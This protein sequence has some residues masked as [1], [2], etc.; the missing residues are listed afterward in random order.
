MANRFSKMT[1]SKYQ[2]LSMQEIMAVPMAMQKQHDTLQA[3]AD[4]AALLEAQYGSADKEGA[5]ARV[6][7]L[8]SKANSISSSLGDTGFNRSLLRDF[9]ALK[10]ETELEYGKN[11]Y[12]GKVQANAVAQSKF[13]N[14]LATDK[15]RQAGWSPQEAQDW[16]RRQVSEFGPTRNDDGTYN[17]FQGREL[18][19]KFEGEDE[20]LDAAIERVAEQVTPATISLVKS[21]GIGALE[22][23]YRTRTIEKKDY[24]TLMDAMVTSAS[25]NP[26]LIRSL[27]QEA[28]MYGIEDPLDFGS[29][30]TINEPVLDDS[31]K[32]VMKSG[33]AVTKPVTDFT[34]GK[35]RM[36][37][38]IAGFGRAAQYVN[39]KDAI[40]IK[41][42]EAAKIAFE[43]GQDAESTAGMVNIGNGE[44][45][46]V[47]GPTFDIDLELMNAGKQNAKIIKINLD[48]LK[49]KL[50]ENGATPEQ[51]KGDKEVQRLNAAWIKSSAKYSNAEQ[52]LNNASDKADEKLTSSQLNRIKF[53]DMIAEKYS[54]HLNT[55]G[56]MNDIDGNPTIDFERIL[57]EEYGET[58][59]NYSED[60]NNPSV[61]DHDPKEVSTTGWAS[62]GS[63]DKMALKILEQKLGLENTVRGGDVL[64]NTNHGFNFQASKLKEI[65][66]ENRNEYLAANP[67]A[68]YFNIF[69]G[70]ATGKNYSNL[71]GRNE[72]LTQNF[73]PK[74]SQLAYGKGMLTDNQEYLDLL[75]GLPDTETP[76][77]KVSLTDG[78]DDDGT[79]FNNLLVTTS[80]GTGSF[81]IL[82]A[83]NNGAR[84]DLFES[85]VNGGNSDQIAIGMQGLANL[86]HMGNIKSS[87]FGKQPTGT[88]TVKNGETNYEATYKQSDTENF[89]VVT[90]PGP[91][92]TPISISEQPI[93]S[94]ADLSLKLAKAVKEI[95]SQI[96]KE[97]DPNYDAT[98]DT[99]IQSANV[100]PSV[101]A[102][103]DGT[104]VEEPIDESMDFV[105][106]NVD[107][108]GSNPVT[109]TSEDITQ[110]IQDDMIAEDPDMQVSTPENTMQFDEVSAEARQ[111]LDFIGEFESK[112]G[113]PDI[114]Y[115]GFKG[116]T[117]KPLTQM[118]LDEVFALQ[119]RMVNEQREANPNKLASSAV[120]SHQFINSTL[121]EE[122]KR[123]GLSGSTVFTGAVQDSIMIGRLKNSRG[124]DQFLSGDM[125]DVEFAESLSKEFA[126]MPNPSTNRSYYDGD[127]LNSSLVGI[128]KVL[129]MLK[130]LKTTSTK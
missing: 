105:D 54:G 23:A 39:P 27:R 84:R 49:D 126:S 10:A 86:E 120:G 117:E 45:N 59:I 114:L 107:F 115:G 76:V 77:I 46:S 79:F 122:V 89:Y 37:Q 93:Y 78:Q 7:E 64:V 130:K 103:I 118:T 33:V 35:S 127:G 41:T 18:V 71:G 70:S 43:R 8:R 69:S 4:K 92:G 123:Q 15:A 9:T 119:T 24:I 14:D 21:G 80:K 17:S 125:T 55:D 42:D 116:T 99:D 52:R 100:A 82:D 110:F 36:G 44:L 66:T 65:R 83:S 29:F 88:L 53:Q 109:G 104:D 95:N 112:G 113:D 25:T 47:T 11:G 87:G 108:G 34:P 50:A 31:G 13:V 40:T 56:T 72:I 2:P 1:T 26:D 74:G 128:N 28:E 32:P 81:Q 97:S 62:K 73:N 67:T 22:K 51:I 124:F 38:K 90:I 3:Q 30:A 111:L 16:A 94:R 5:E 102:V 101:Q 129:E 58:I 106:M 121:K 85:F 96:A 48:K 20:L 12:L 68:E 19:T 57:F 91:G 63:R 98:T 6:S 60:P 75:D 61:G